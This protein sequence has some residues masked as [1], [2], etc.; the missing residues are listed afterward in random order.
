MAKNVGCSRDQRDL[1][2]PN[3]ALKRCSPIPPFVLAEKT[4]PQRPEVHRLE[5]ESKIA[6]MTGPLQPR[7]VLDP[8][9]VSASGSLAASEL[10]MLH[11]ESVPRITR[12]LRSKT[13]PSQT[14]F[15]PRKRCSIRVNE[16]ES[17]RRNDDHSKVTKHAATRI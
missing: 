14:V 12:A 11:V 2:K 7:S 8:S 13:N 15:H 3:Q 16:L 9:R 17:L 1:R 4:E 10:L 5:S 6:Q